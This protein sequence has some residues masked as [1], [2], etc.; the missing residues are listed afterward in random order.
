MMYPSMKYKAIDLQHR[1][2]HKF[3]DGWSSLDQWDEDVGT[4]HV[5]EHTPRTVDHYSVEGDSYAHSSFTV[6]VTSSGDRPLPDMEEVLQDSFG[7]SSCRHEYDCCGCWS[8]GVHNVERLDD[9]V[10][11]F[12]ISASRN[13]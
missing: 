9:S 1:L 6:L 13:Y 10:W 11:S 5:L 8:Y 3:R 12:D 4:A 7:G 2:S